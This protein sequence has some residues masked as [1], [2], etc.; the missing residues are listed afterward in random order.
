MIMFDYVSLH[1]HTTFSIMDALVTPSE[2][3]ERTKELGQKA[4]AVTDHGTLA[5]MW[6]CLKASKKTGVKLIAGCE[7]YFVND[8]ANEE[9]LRHLVLLAKN[10]KGYE[11]L[12]MLNKKGFDNF[13]LMVSLPC[14]SLTLVLL[15]FIKT[16]LIVILAMK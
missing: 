11:N 3:F 9:Q 6:D 2:L 14:L 4:V 16:P 5:G 12:L 10:A 1:N 8:V 7:C 13:K 15:D